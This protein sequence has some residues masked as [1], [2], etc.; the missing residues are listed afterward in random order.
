MILRVAAMVV[1]VKTLALASPECL[2][3]FQTLN[4]NRAQ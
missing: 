3:M 4:P 1:L 2:K